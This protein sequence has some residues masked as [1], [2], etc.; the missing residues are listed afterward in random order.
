MG[1]QL[2]LG[3]PFFMSMNER[4]MHEA[5]KLAEEAA[6]N[7]E[8]PVGAVVVFENRII[9]K[10]SNRRETDNLPTAH[11]EI[12]AIEEA[13]RE[14][15]S[16]RLENCTL[17][18]TLEPCIMCSGTIVQ[19]RIPYVYYG[20]R[21]PKAGGVVSLYSVLQDSRLNHQAEVHGG[22]LENEC[23]SILKD[24]FKKI[25]SDKKRVEH[26]GEVSESG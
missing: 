10:G 21:D 12:I 26:S 11:A 20:A 2:L 16:W 7:G 9:G 1:V 8:V 5:L 22:I 23:S 3:T 6:E 25:R 19:A 17:Y 4:Y 13:A 15:E 14:L 18:V 24:F